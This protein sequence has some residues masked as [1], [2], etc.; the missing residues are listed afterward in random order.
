MKDKAVVLLS[1][2][3][4][5][6][7]N[8]AIAKEEAVLALTFDYGQKAGEK[9]IR[10]SRKL[11]E[12]YQVLHQ[13]VPLTWLGK[14]SGSALTGDELAL[15]RLP[16]IS[17]ASLDTAAAVWVPNRNGLFVNIGAAFAES[18]GAEWVIFGAN[19]EEAGTFPDNSP[20]FIKAANLAFA[21]STKKRVRLKSYTRDLIKSEMI[22]KAVLLKLPLELIWSCY[23]A[24]EKMCGNC[25]SCVRLQSG[26]KNAGLNS[27]EMGRF[28]F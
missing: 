12:F 10:F 4:D 16:S 17:R 1:S 23:Q 19:K 21:F 2:G 24:G 5:S 20:A 3:L 11:A 18:L 9:E 14:L 15:P 25:E 26:A 22:K 6:A 8:L 13:V 7:L 28:N 27:Q